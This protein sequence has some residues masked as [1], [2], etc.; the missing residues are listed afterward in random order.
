VLAPGSPD[1][2]LQIIDGRD[3]GR[4]VVQLLED[5]RQG[6]FHTVWPD[7]SEATF[8]AVLSR[9][10]EAVAPPGTTLTWVDSEFLTQHGVDGT[11]LPLWEPGEESGAPARPDAALRA[12]LRPR[13]VQQTAAELLQAERT[14]P[15]PNVYGA[16]LPADREAELL[17]AWWAHRS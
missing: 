6:T 12:G 1:S 4:F 11:Q 9:V 17:A 7:V 14:H 8:G 10:A 15:S 16:G 3:Q 2:W 13:P 5:D